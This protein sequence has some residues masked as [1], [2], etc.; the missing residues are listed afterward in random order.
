MGEGKINNAITLDYDMFMKFKQRSDKYD[1][2]PRKCTLNP[3]QQQQ[4]QKLVSG[5]YSDLSF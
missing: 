4:V 1:L 2:D 5:S 3:K